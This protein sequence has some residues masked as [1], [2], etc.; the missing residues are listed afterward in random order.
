M[1]LF[2]PPCRGGDQGVVQTPELTSPPRFAQ[3]LSFRRRG[4]GK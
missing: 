3:H 2:S 4:L 1:G